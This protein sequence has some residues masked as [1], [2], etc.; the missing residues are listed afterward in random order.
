MNR[1]EGITRIYS[2]APWR[3]QSQIV[4][5]ILVVVVFSTLFAT[6]YLHISARTAEVGRQIQVM[7]NEIDELDRMNEDL[8]SQLA[9]IKSSEQMEQRA[10]ALGFK[11]VQKDEITFLSVPGYM[12]PPVMVYQHQ[13][14]EKPPGRTKLPDEYT[15]SLFDWMRRKATFYLV[16]R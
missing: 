3:K 2:Q 10:E 12:E 4:G 15:E 11:P 8:R 13:A 14:V 1:I 16:V 7:Q 9:L 5:L 6:V